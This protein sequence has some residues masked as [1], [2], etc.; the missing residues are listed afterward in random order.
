MY[1][2]RERAPPSGGEQGAFGL[3]LHSG[4]ARR[5]RM[6]NRHK[7]RPT[8]LPQAGKSEFSGRRSI[9]ASDLFDTVMNYFTPDVVQKF[10]A[11]L[12]ESPTT[13]QRAMEGAVPTLLAGL[14]NFASSG[15]G[16]TQ[17]ANLL[18]QGKYNNILNN[19]SGL[20]GGGSETQNLTNT[21]Q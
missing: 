3:P 20:L 11:L 13:T 4:A 15:D 14:T 18:S 6:C 10:S 2:H 16:A 9:M 8:A 5:W 21:G 12:G 19:L 17:L 1:R 7:C